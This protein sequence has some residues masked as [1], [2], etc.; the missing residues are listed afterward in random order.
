MALA[1]VLTLGACKATGG[2]P[3][4]PPERALGRLHRRGELRLQLHLRG[5]N[6]KKRAVIRGTITYHDDP[7]TI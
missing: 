1:A 2:G 6:G 7:S 5:G 4:A 3:V